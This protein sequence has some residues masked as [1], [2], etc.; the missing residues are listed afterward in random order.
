MS[1]T[2]LAALM[3]GLLVASSWGCDSKQDN[4]P[5]AGT[6]QQAAPA[7]AGSSALD[8]VMENILEASAV[9]RE[10]LTGMLET[11]VAHTTP[12]ERKQFW[13]VELDL[14]EAYRGF[15]ALKDQDPGIVSAFCSDWAAPLNES[16]LQWDQVVGIDAQGWKQL[17][18]LSAPGGRSEW[19][20]FY[21]GK[22]SP[23]K[24]ITLCD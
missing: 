4:D 1:R 23:A 22:Q 3:T 6:S 9:E 16:M 17:L 8:Q 12:E 11:G 5:A 2:I 18:E 7:P 24:M 21:L 10:A 19:T 20:L 15:W 13:Q 14:M